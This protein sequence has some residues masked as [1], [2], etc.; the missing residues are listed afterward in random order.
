MDTDL[1]K[2]PCHQCGQKTTPLSAMCVKHKRLQE[3]L[4]RGAHRA[5]EPLSE[6]DFAWRKAMQEFMATMPQSS[7]RVKRVKTD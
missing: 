6:D 1:G 4:L 5:G 2:L 3:A 7:K